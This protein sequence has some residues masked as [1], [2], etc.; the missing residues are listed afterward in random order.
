MRII[1]D[2]DVVVNV[3]LE[4]IPRLG[5][6]LVQLTS[7]LFTLFLMLPRAVCFLVLAGARLSVFSTIAKQKVKALYAGIQSADG[8]MRSFMQE[9][10]SNLMVTHTFTREES[11][12]C[13]ADEYAD[14]L[15]GAFC[16]G[17]NLL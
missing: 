3:L 2:A 10:L 13:Q 17:A 11:A 7:A 15:V 6:I 16:I 12:I 14:R 8:V 1:S 9:S 4:D 5:G